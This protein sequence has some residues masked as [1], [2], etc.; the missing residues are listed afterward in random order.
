MAKHLKLTLP[1]HAAHVAVTVDFH[2]DRAPTPP[3][4]RS[5]HHVRLPVGS[6]RASAGL[7]R[8]LRTP[9]R[10]R[11]GRASGGAP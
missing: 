6:L 8:V 3:P 2:R 4:L 11:G 1:R 9:P 10:H 5:S 7:A